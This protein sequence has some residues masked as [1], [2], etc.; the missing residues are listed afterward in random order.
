[1]TARF[2]SDDSHPPHAVVPE[3]STWL[4]TAPRTPGAT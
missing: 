1:M 4:G 2:L 3:S